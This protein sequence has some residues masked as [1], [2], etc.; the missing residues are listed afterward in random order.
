[1][2]IFKEDPFA[3][4]SAEEE[5]SFRDAIFYQPNYY[6]GLKTSVKNNASRFLLGQRGDG[7]SVVIYK[8]M[9]DLKMEQ[10]LPILITRYDDIPITD[11]KQHFLFLICKNIVI[12]VAREL[13]FHPEIRNNIERRLAQRLSQYIE[14]FYDGEFSNEFIEKA[15]EIKLIKSK[16]WYKK[17]VNKNFIKIINELIGIGMSVS[18]SALKNYIGVPDMSLYESRR[19][20]SEL[21]LAEIKQI[22]ISNAQNVKER[23]YIQI[24]KDLTQILN[25]MGFHSIVILFDK[26]DECPRINSDTEKIADFCVEILTDTDLLLSSNLSIVFSLWSEIKMLLSN[27]SVRFDKFGEIKV[28]L[29]NS[30]IERLLD[31]R[32]KYFSSDSDNPVSFATLIP[33]KAY[34]DEILQI[35]DKSPRTLLRL[36]GEIYNNQSDRQAE[37]FEDNAI[38]DGLKSFCKTFEFGALRPTSQNDIQLKDWINKLLQ[39]RLVE[40]SSSQVKSVF[41]LTG[42]ASDTYIQNFI[43]YGLVKSSGRNND[44]GETIYKIIDPRIQYLISRGISELE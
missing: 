42:K 9:N 5:E 31:I 18:A 32:L 11:N 39:I 21:E 15:K 41:K 23:H 25:S 14:M 37:S 28:T 27:R 35:A 40:L 20:I 8:L 17:I 26:I 22:D 33:N 38:V 43:K 44:S 6:A 36:L 30:E 29:R 13:F 12:N 2:R 4:Y 10:S 3:Q 34:R 7:K 24:I 19:F 1:V 16:N